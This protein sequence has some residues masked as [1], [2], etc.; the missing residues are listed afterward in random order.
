M[1][2]SSTREYARSGSTANTDNPAST[3]YPVHLMC[4]HQRKTHYEN[5]VLTEVVGLRFTF[6][7]F[8]LKVV[9]AHGGPTCAVALI[10]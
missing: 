1:T 4:R 8:L 6:V 10:D 5:L 3:I 9:G 7:G 2:G